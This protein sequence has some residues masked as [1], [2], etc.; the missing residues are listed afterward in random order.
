MGKRGAFWVFILGTL[1][2]AVLFLYLTYDTHKQVAVLTHADQ[3][4]DD[5]VAGKRVW[6]KYNCNDC[7]TILGFGGYYA[8]DMTK[9]YARIGAAWIKTVLSDPGKAFASSWRKMPNQHLNDSEIER[10]TA[11]LKWVSEIDNNDWPP[12]DNS[13]TTLK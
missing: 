9:A 1:S 11:F 10:L 5:V 12:Q 13:K 8:P 6:E 4:S 2:S 3:L 7:H